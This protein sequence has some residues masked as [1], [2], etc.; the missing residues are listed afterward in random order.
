MG[1]N[2]I[3]RAADV[4]AILDNCLDKCVLDHAM[5]RGK[6]IIISVPH[7]IPTS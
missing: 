5:L 2:S 3:L 1:Q 6:A 4:S 7:T